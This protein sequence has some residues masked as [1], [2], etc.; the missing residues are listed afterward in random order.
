MGAVIGLQLIV[1][2]SAVAQVALT[3]EFTY[4]GRLQID[5][6]P[7]NDSADFEFTLWDAETGG[8]QIG[9]LLEANNLDIVDGVFTVVL[10][11]GVI[12][13]NG[14]ARWL[15]VAVRSPAGVGGFTTLSP[16]QAL[17]AAPYALQTRGLF[18]DDQRRVG[19]GNVSPQHL[20]SVGE[21]TADAG[22]VAA[23]VYSTN[24]STWNGAAALGGLSNSVILG[25]LFGVATVGGHNFALSTWS[26]LSLN[27]FGGNVGIGTDAPRYKLHNT[28][29]YYGLG[30]IILHAYEGDGASGTAYLQAR[31]DSGVSDIAMQL[32]TQ[33]AGTIVEAVNISST[34]NVGIGTPG[35]TDQLTV[36]GTIKSTTG[37]FVFPD[38]TTQT[39]AAMTTQSSWQMN[40]NGIHY[41]GG[42]VAI[43]T[44][45]ASLPFRV[46]G[47]GVGTVVVDQ[48]SVLNGICNT[49]TDSEQEFVPGVT[50]YLTSVV[51]W[52]FDSGG[53]RIAN[54][55]VVEGAHG[56]AGAVLAVGNIAVGPGNS[57]VTFDFAAEPP[58]LVAGQTYRL[59]VQAT[60]GYVGP[61]CETNPYPAGGAWF[62]GAPS[63]GDTPFATYMAPE[64]PGASDRI[65]VDNIGRV[66]I[67][68]GQPISTL[69][70]NGD[71]RV[72]T[73]ITTGTSLSVGTSISAGTTMTTPTL[74]ITGGA[75]IAEPYDIA[76]TRDVAPQSGH[77][78]SID[79]AHIGK[80][81][82][83]GEAYDAT[84]AGIISGAGGVKPGLT[85]TQHDSVAQGEHPVAMNG[86][87]WCWVD[88]DEGGPVKA[89]DLLTTSNTPGHAMKVSDVSRSHGAT[90]GKAMSSLENGRGLVLVL[91]SLQ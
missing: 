37:G 6:S 45:D 46:A 84:V 3:N 62:N 41:D 87:V 21:P 5:G 88:A 78:V 72:A 35:S 56:Q 66:G 51:T 28:G 53:N 58:Y 44:T 59:I 48:Q 39:T 83:S 17:S 24:Q 12:A 42:N 85:L 33:T 50:G 90:I 79:P 1:S 77:V 60:S 9:S 20:L 8:N 29:D 4:Q 75:D 89:G 86:R 16:R 63:T 47:T 18:V 91:V 38:G 19:I 61:T 11:F 68:T 43:E 52:I 25:E 82:I 30:H 74:F 64:I 32:R 40:A 65:V 34:G 15:E 27:P 2:H 73:S 55:Q 71:A 13:F 10:D 22:N 23:R 31:D 57:A 70:V 54:L 67:G 76:A 80:L 81:R 36:A 49:F 69:D 14:D 26:D 7:L